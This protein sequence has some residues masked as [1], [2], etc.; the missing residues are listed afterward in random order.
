MTRIDS[1]K[2][3]IHY[4]IAISAI[5]VAA[6]VA[7]VGGILAIIPDVPI[8]AFLVS[9]FIAALI[10]LIIAPP[11]SYV[12][13]SLLLQVTETLDRV[14]AQIRFDPLTGV[15]NRGY[16]LDQ[17]RC[18]QSGGALLI[19][20]ADHFKTINDNYGHSA[21]DAALV[22]L[23]H[24]M[25]RTVGVEGLTGRLGG[26]EFA[27]FLP[28]LTLAEGAA[29]AEAICA[30]IRKLDPLIEGHRI[31]LTVSIGCTLH[32][33]SALIGKSLKQADI[34]LY[35]AKANGRDQVAHDVMPREIS[36]TAARPAIFG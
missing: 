29:F 17:I 10:P 15:L 21:G 31:K 11:V 22:V 5:A 25:S 3:V 9:L 23:S 7:V 1:K 14:D 18:S 4:T 36:G 8:F 12:G 30:N 13:L 34:L 20:D 16:L 32:P 6:P 26:E 24:A 2:K 27:I 35:R 28:G 33:K 19:V